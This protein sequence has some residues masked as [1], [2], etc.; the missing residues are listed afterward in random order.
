VKLRTH[1]LQLLAPFHPGEEVVPGARL[2]GV[3]TEP[4]L[5]WRFD[6]DAGKVN[7]QVAL[8]ADADRFAGVR[9]ISP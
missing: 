2:V 5:G 7:V 8:A 9:R 6:T 1:L 4:G 3:L